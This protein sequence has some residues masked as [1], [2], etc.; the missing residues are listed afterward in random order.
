MQAEEN[1]LYSISFFRDVDGTE[2]VKDYLENLKQKER[3]KAFVYIQM[4]SRNGP[5]LKRPY[6]DNLGGGLGLWE[7]RPGR[8]RILYFFYARRVIILCHAFLK[9]TDSI[10]EKEINIAIKRKDLVKRGCL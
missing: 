6:A 4:L 5:M 8:H 7:L 10:P 2:P 1:A 3:D 9:K